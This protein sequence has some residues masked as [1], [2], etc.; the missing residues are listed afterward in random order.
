MMMIV[1]SRCLWIHSYSSLRGESL[2]LG[3]S[4]VSRYLTCSLMII[5]VVRMIMMMMMTM[6]MI[7]MIMIML[8]P[9]D[10]IQP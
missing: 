8:A 3:Q 1:I 9:N 10:C 6:T 5:M 7:R 2:A 4:S